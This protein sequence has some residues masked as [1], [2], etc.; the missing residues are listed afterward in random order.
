MKEFALSQLLLK[1]IS[2]PNEIPK[3]EKDLLNYENSFLVEFFLNFS[4]LES[5]MYDY[6]IFEH[7]L[8]L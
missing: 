3:I 5:F 4:K 7:R 1:G 6:F 8:N 2:S